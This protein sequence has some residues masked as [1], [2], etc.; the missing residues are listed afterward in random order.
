MIK[1]GSKDIIKMVDIIF[2]DHYFQILSKKF[3][4][5]NNNLID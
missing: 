2:I 5:I 1:N 4:Q 3:F